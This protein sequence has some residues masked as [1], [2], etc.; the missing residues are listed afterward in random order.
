MPLQR[1]LF[2]ALLLPV[3]ACGDDPI[4]PRESIGV[5]GSITLQDGFEIPP[6]AR[7]VVGWFK[8]DD[9]PELFEIYGEASLPQTSTT[10][11]L[12]LASPPPASAMLGGLL[13]IGFILVTADAE[14]GDGDFLEAADFDAL[15]GAGG[16]F[17]V[18]WTDGDP[19]IAQ[20]IDWAA[21]FAPGYSVGR[22][23]PRQDDFDAFEPAPDG[24]V[25]LEI[26]DIDAIEFVDFT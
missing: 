21:D 12:T 5:S 8:G 23:V 11:S 13:G 4:A 10:F 1:F 25:I 24:A 22:G 20:E 19:R 15:A 2:A 14:L 7:V 26:G 6:G 18:I 16:Q 3:I 17:A 9:Q